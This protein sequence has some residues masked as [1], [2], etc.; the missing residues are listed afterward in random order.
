MKRKN[1]LGK[2]FGRLTV[3]CFA[4]NSSLGKTMWACLCD[5]GNKRIIE[6]SHLQT[7]NTKSCGCYRAG[8]VGRKAKH[9]QHGSIEYKTWESMITRCTNPNASNYAYYGGRGITVCDR[10]RD[11]RLFFADMGS[12]G[13]KKLTIERI[14]NNKG[15][16]PKNC[17]WASKTAQC[18]NSRLDK[19]NRTGFRG[20]FW[21]EQSKKYRASIS[22]DRKLI[23]LG[24]FITIHEAA[25]ARKKGE[26]EYWGV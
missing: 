25:V 11:F 8:R 21:H 19:R 24:F 23:T 7:G 22:V 16:E 15:Y 14:D 4:K 6:S 20:V 1:L 3:V 10:W 26:L 5:C 18:R 13:S 2:K 9:G 12:R 17:C